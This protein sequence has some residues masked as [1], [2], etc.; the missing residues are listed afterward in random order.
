MKRL[1]V[2]G[3]GYIGLPTALHAARHGYDVAGFDTDLEK[4]RTINAG[5]PPV[6]ERGLKEA[7][8]AALHEK[9]F[10]AY[11]EIAPADYFL[12]TVPT[13]FCADKK[14][15]LTYVYQAINSIAQVL[16]PT[17]TV[18]LE[19]TVPV[20]TTQKIITLLQEKTHL[21]AGVDFYLAHCPERILP[22]RIFEELVSNDRVIGG[23]NK[24]S[25]EH[26]AEFYAAFVE[27]QL[28][29]TDDKTAE[30][31][32]LVENSSRDVAIA[33]ANQVASMAYNSGIHPHEVIA[34]ANK[35]PRVNILNP[36]VGVGGHCIAVDPWFLISE[37]PS[38][39]SLLQTARAINDARPH[40]IINE[41]SGAIE[42][43][44]KE[45]SLERPLKLALFGLT[46]KPDID[47]I[48]ESPALEIAHTFQKRSDLEVIVCEPNLSKEKLTELGFQHVMGLWQA[49]ADADIVAILVTHKEFYA[50]TAR[51]VQNKKYIDPCGLFFRSSAP[52]KSPQELPFS[53]YKRTKSISAKGL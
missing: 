16:E 11:P 28:F 43:F 24:V 5:V 21:R 27:S 4:I 23:V 26:A 6:I 3:L 41:I 14:P 32:K 38:D 53:I 52:E 36:G 47:D 18:I 2:I 8:L 50:L 7:L 9:T 13:P 30:M 34:L 42:E 39:S 25:A 44:K 15:D 12:I 22:G 40:E 45:N 17:N 10:H 46:Y 29:L 51:D 48:R 49:F 35:H 19:S 31:V 33:F 20:G 1:S 37:L